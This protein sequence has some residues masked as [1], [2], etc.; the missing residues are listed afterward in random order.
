MENNYLIPANTKKSQYYLGLFTLMELIMVGCAAL[1]LILILLFVHLSNGILFLLLAFLPPLIVAFLVF[2][3]QYYHN[4]LQLLVNI[5]SFYR[6]RRRY[7]WKGWSKDE[8]FTTT[9]E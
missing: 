1:W 9:N 4:M 3:V 7:Y 8:G 5:G 2:P 6:N